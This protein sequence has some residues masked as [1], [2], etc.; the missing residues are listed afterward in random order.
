[1]QYFFSSFRI[2][3]KAGLDRER[4]LFFYL[5]FEGINVKDTSSGTLL[6]PLN[7]ELVL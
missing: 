3:P 4:L 1:M 5:V 2:I 7:P 6:D